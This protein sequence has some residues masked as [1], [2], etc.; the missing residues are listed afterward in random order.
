MTGQRTRFGATRRFFS[1]DVWSVELGGVPTFKRL[2]Y[3]LARIAYLTV[4]GVDENRLLMRASALT[5]I[6]V[7]SLVPLL[8]FAFS[9]AKG[10]GF[11]DRLLHDVIEPFLNETLGATDG[12]EPA[13]GELRHAIDQVLAF[14]QDANVTSLGGFGLAILLY[15]VIKLLGS[16][17]GAFN[18]IWGVHRART[19]VR[20]VADYLSIVVIVPILLITAGTVTTAAQSEEAVAYVREQLGLGTLVEIYA[21]FSSLVAVWLGFCFVYLFMPNTRVRVRSAL[22]GGIVGGTL[23]QVAQVL[24]VRFQVGVANY[25]AIYSTFAA[26]PIFMFWLYMSWV[27]VL[28]GAETAFA[29]QNE[30]AHRQITRARAHDQV[31][32]ERLGLRAVLRVALRFLRGDPPDRA[33]TLAAELQVPEPSLQRVVDRLVSAGILARTGEDEENPG[34][35][36]ARDLDRLRVHDVLDAV[37]ERL[38]NGSLPTAEPVD[39]T[40]AEVLDHLEEERAATP[41]NLTLRALAERCLDGE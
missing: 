1:T 33:S 19:L 5:F 11:Y 14:V 13:A 18:D 8:A 15:T 40:L 3:R 26:L 41:H 16:I 4:R 21:R 29:H 37:G 6:T 27:T 34:L 12:G 22:L 35:L 20:K 2:F 17:E 30:P 9:M 31:F 25:S 24:H 39:R 10:L 7:L 38:G 23:W 32:L 36:P 28:L